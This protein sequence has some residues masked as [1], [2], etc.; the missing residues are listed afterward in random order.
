MDPA[1]RVSIGKVTVSH[2]KRRRRVEF[3][4]FHLLLMGD[5]AL[6]SQQHKP[7][8]SAAAWVLSDPDRNEPHRSDNDQGESHNYNG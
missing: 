2:K 3:L 8:L 6:H 1:Q 7:S 5:T 4:E